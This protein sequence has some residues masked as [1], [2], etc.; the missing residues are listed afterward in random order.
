M[1]TNNQTILG[2]IYEV[3]MQV[4]EKSLSVEKAIEMIRKIVS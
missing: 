1:E 4:F 3:V 2:Y